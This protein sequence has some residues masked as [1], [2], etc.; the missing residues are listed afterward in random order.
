[1]APFHF[2][3]PSCVRLRGE[4]DLRY[5]R[6][7]LDRLE[8]RGRPDAAVQADD[9]GAL[10]FELLNEKLGGRA[11]QGV[12][13]L[14]RRH[15]RDNRERRQA[16]HRTDG[17]TDLVQI[18]E[19]LE[20]EQVDAAFEERRRL[21]AEVRLCFVDARLSPGFDTYAE[22][23][24]R[25]SDERLIVGRPPREPGSLGVDFR[26]PIRQTEGRELDSIRTEGVGL[27]DVGAR[28][29]VRVVHFGD[30][31]RLGQVE[32]VER[33]IQE[34]APR[35]EHRPHRPVADEHPAIELLEK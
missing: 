17:G 15:L 3:R 28:P 21:L 8:H 19:S 11:V 13:I 24:D 26:R 18:A 14:F 1:M 16:A 27:D 7:A 34:D 25:A 30:E 20:H 22:R 10:F 2:A 6:D 9:G 29:H 31:I 23:P 33:A 4:R 32:L 35:I 12:A 5:A